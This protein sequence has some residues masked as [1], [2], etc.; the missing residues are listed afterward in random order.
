MAK[1]SNCMAIKLTPS[2]K[3][4][5]SSSA[6]V[7]SLYLS[8]VMLLA[9]N[10]DEIRHLAN[11]A[12]VDCICITETWLKCHIH[13]NVIAL[14]GFNL[15]RKDRAVIDHGGICDFIRNIKD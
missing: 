7:P 6:F 9:P 8:N 14:D 5:G 15:V 13:D 12:N 10:I 11:Y 1:I 3:Q 4:Q 2:Q